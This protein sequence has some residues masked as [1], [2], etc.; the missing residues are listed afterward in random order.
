MLLFCLCQLYTDKS[1]LISEVA[2]VQIYYFFLCRNPYF[3]KH[4]TSLKCV[5]QKEIQ[6]ELPK[7]VHESNILK[8]HY[9]LPDPDVEKS[10]SV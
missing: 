8:F 5:N 2:A 9:E 7:D 3:L 4:Q 6:H 10:T 1:E